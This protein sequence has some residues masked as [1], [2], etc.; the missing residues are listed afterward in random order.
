MDADFGSN[1]TDHDSDNLEATVK[2][3]SHVCVF[4]DCKK[5]KRGAGI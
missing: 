5:G 1:I 2:K 4:G 3:L